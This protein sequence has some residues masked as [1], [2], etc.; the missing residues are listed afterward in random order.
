MKLAERVVIDVPID[1]VWKIIT[2]IPSMALCIPG[3]EAAPG[4]SGKYEANIKARVGPLTINVEGTLSVKETD[5]AAKRTVLD[6]EGVVRQAGGGVQ[7]TMTFELS[8]PA[9]GKT[10]IHSIADLNLQRTLAMLDNALIKRKAKGMFKE[11]A[12]NLAERANQ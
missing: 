4:N 9:A 6:V 1:D 12:K 5:A 7:G 3:A 2:D 11:F 8:E 10:E